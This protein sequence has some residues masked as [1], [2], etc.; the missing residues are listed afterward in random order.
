MHLLV[1]RFSAMG[2]VALTIPVLRGVL[3]KNPELQITMVSEARFEPM[4]HDI[5]RLNFYRVNMDN[6][7]G[8]F[9]LFRLFRELRALAAWDAIIDLHSVMRSWVLDFFFRLTLVPVFKI[10]KGRKEKKELAQKENKVVKQLKHTTQRY[11][12]VFKKF[13]VDGAVEEGR[14]LHVIAGAKKS[15]EAYLAEHELIKETK[16]LGIAPFS[17]HKQKTWPLSKITGLIEALTAHGNYQIF[18]LGGN[19]EAAEL[20]N[21]A[22]LYPNCV[23]MAGVF[24]LDEEIALMHEL[25]V[26]VAMDSFNMHLAALCNTKVV[27]VWG[28][29]HPFAGFGPLNGNDKFIIQ[30]PHEQLNCRPCSVFGSKP[31]YR[32]DWACLKGVEVEEI[33][34]NI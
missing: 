27:S 2:D 15:L 1:I 12:D 20:R 29:T 22:S 18:L 6:Y 16:W 13:G 19:E 14:V 4:F 24:T 17:K 25:D 8:F 32:G 3:K 26:V 5:E 9:G 34:K 23:N 30:V 7:P 31:C 10:D 33:M 21:L 11:L 28:G